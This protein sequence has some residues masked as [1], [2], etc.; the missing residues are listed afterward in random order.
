ML[1]FRRRGHIPRYCECAIWKV[2]PGHRLSQASDDG[3][4][5][6]PDFAAIAGGAVSDLGD[7]PIRSQSQ[8]MPWAYACIVR[9]N[10]ILGTGALLAFIGVAA[11]A[12]G[13]HALKD[14]LTASQ[15]AIYQTG[16]QYHLLHALALVAIGAQTRFEAKWPAWLFT[17]GI[18]IF[19]G[20]LYA[21][22]IT[23]TTWWGAITPIGGVCFLAGWLILTIKAFSAKP[24]ISAD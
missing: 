21:L 5:L 11:G 9:E 6:C 2:Q 10:R 3:V 8:L 13:A 22:A 14:Q 24:S 15:L 19:S 7:A 4:A 23:G 17:A 16:V 20:S 1:P 12:F 18:V